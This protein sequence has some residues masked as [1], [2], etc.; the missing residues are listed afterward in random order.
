MS[1]GG[2]APPVPAIQDYLSTKYSR[3]AWPGAAPA[4]DR[5][6]CAPASRAPHQPHTYQAARPAAPAAGDVL[7]VA[8]AGNAGNSSL[9]VP[10]AYGAVISVAATDPGN[11][12]IGFSEQRC[13]ARD[14]LALHLLCTYGAGGRRQ[15]VSAPAVPP[16]A[17]TACC[18]RAAA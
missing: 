17:S 14:Q 12:R 2:L 18:R 11:A 3:G 10:A 6:L 5:R 15:G 4:Q 7:F 1:L 16:G 8:A 13:R 9:A